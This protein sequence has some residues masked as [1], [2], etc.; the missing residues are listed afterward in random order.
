MTSKLEFVLKENDFLKNK[1]VSIS[2]ELDLISNENK[3]LK[4]DFD[5]HVCHASIP[6]SSNVSIAYSSSSSNVENDLC[7]L[8]KSVDCLCS[9]LSQGA[10]DHKKLDSMFHKKRTAH[11]HAHHPQHTPHVH[12]DHIHSHMYARV[13]TCT[14]CVWPSCKILL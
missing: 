13:Y 9:T 5:S 12:H 6:S 10:M 7:I 2:K 4:N 3:S 14:H 1:I 8:K 11:I